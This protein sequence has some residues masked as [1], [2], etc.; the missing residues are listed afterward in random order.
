MNFKL[1]RQVSDGRVSFESKSSPNLKKPYEVWSVDA[2][3]YVDH[4]IALV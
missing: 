1:S 3:A 4:V 2:P